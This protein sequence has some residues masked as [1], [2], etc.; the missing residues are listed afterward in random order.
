MVE[1]QQQVKILMAHSEDTENRLRHNNVRVVGLS[2]GEEGTNPVVFAEVFFKKL[3]GL[4]HLSPV[5]IVER[6]NRVSTGWRP[7]GAWPR[8][9]LKVSQPKHWVALS[10]HSPSNLHS[11]A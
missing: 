11:M 3:L 6:A 5:Y 2:E 9:F 7:A 4:Q 10:S 8:A 1:L